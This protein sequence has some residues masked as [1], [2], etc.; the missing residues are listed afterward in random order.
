MSTPPAGDSYGKIGLP[1]LVACEVFTSFCDASVHSTPHNVTP[2]Q[3]CGKEIPYA[4]T[5]RRPGDVAAVYGDAS[6]AHAELG[7]KAE[8]GL[9]DMCADSWRWISKNPNGFSSSD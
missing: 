4:L 7:W 5:D 9:K 8:L 2:L 6:L 1:P 3:A